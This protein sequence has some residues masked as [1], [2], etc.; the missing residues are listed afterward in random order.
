MSQRVCRNVV[1][2]FV[3][4]AAACGGDG[5]STPDASTVDAA[6]DA[7][8]HK[9]GAVAA[10]ED[11]AQNMTYV[12]GNFFTDTSTPVT[13][14]DDGPC[15]I[16]LRFGA[17]ALPIN[18]GT[19]SVT[20]G[21]TGLFTIQFDPANGGYF[22][23]ASGLTYAADA[24]ITARATGATVPAFTQTLPFPAPV[25]V[26][27]AAPTVL[28]K[29]G[30]TATWTATTSPVVIDVS[31]YSSGSPQLSIRCVFDGTTG[32][33]TIPAT[34]LAEVQTTTSVGIGIGTQQTA[35][36]MVGDYET[37]MFTLHQRLNRNN[38]PV[39]P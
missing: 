1:V 25:T 27:S 18:A 22:V 9:R 6:P 32:T 35:H 36:F 11:A 31:Q 10:V 30:F 28:H 23:M 4:L 5:N 14:R 20:D 3:M 7:Q 33:G 21:G 12:F 15:H 38:I 17:N 2:G 37:D 13:V 26:T 16:D 29:S 19:L 39:Q 8:V 24:Q 34:A